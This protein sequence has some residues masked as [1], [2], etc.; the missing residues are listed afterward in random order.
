MERVGQ[1]EAG[2]QARRMQDPVQARRELVMRL[3]LL[4]EA[5]RRSLLHSV[6][7]WARLNRRDPNWSSLDFTELDAMAEMLWADTEPVISV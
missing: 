3:R 6:S 2:W 7:S 1:I 5:L 4:Q